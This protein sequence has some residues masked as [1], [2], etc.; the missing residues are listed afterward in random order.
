[1]PLD[2]HLKPTRLG[3][4][5]VAAVVA[6]LAVGCAGASPPAAA[7]AV[8]PA[9]APADR[10]IVRSGTLVLSVDADSVDGTAV[11]V[12]RVVKTVGGLIERES[13]EKQSKASLLCRVPAA[14]LGPIMDR[15]AAL[16]HEQRRSVAAVDRTDQYTDLNAR[17]Q[18]AID[19]RDRLRQLVDSAKTVEETL[20]VEKELARVQADIESMQA[21]LARMKS[22]VA[23]AALSVSIQHKHVL[24]PLG[25]VGYGLWWA[26]SK[27]FLIR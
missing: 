12:E 16:G 25:Y 7:G 27:L 19:L 21:R 26:I 2:R 3:E 5:F 4:A 8:A 20:A 6:A 18:T 24:G 1:M 14:Q 22:E 23:L 10:M 13:I 11:Q 9:Q 17:L 15:L